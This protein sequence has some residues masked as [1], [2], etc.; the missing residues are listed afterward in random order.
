DRAADLA[1]AGRLPGRH[2]GRW[3]HEAASIRQFIQTRCWSERRRSYAWFAGGDDLDAGLL[4]ML[5]MRYSERD[6]PRVL[7][8]VEAIARDLAEGAL[9]RRYDGT[10]GLTGREGAF[11]ACG[12]WLAHALALTGRLDE[13]ARRM[14]ALLDLANDVGLYAEEI[15]GRTGD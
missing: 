7:M 4:H 15:D 11:V 13:A 6:D 5:M 14:E 10:D 12:F 9:L 1:A 8:T 3:R 2:A